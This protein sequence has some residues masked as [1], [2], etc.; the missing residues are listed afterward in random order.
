MRFS[1]SGFGT[2]CMIVD[3]LSGTASP[4]C[5]WL[6]DGV[7]VFWGLHGVEGAS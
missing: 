5:I 1:F 7:W 4:L 6:R 3:A 2:I